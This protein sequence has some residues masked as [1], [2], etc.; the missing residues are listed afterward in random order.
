MSD[1]GYSEKDFENYIVNLL[2]TKSGYIHGSKITK[3]YLTPHQKCTI[4]RVRK[5][6][7]PLMVIYNHHAHPAR[8]FFCPG[9]ASDLKGRHR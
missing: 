6:C 8:F 7:T 9:T 4:L 3:K 1:I 5:P 2:T